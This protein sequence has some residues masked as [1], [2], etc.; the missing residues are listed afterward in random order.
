MLVDEAT[1]TVRSGSGGRGCVSFRREKYVPRGGP[2]G[3]TGGRG[4]SVFLE[5]DSSL[6][7]LLDIS[8]RSL[9]AA[10][11]GRPGGGNNKSGRNGKDLT[12]RLPLGTVV[13]EA[14][15]T[16][17]RA[18]WPLLG[19]LLKAS[20]PLV[21]ARG[22]RGGRGNASFATA[23]YQA[24]REAE[25]GEPAEERKLYLELKLMA[26][27]GLVGLPNAG[28]STL[29]SRIS[30]ATP[31]IAAYP[32]TTLEPHLG[33]VEAG[34]FRRLVFADVPGIIEGAHAGHGLGIE[35]LRHLER[36]RVLV[37]LVSVESLS[38]A[39]AAAAYRTVEAELYQH[40]RVLAEKPRLLAASKL[41]LLP[42]EEGER[43][44]ADLGRLLQVDVLPLSAVTGLGVKALVSAVL[45]LVDGESPAS[46]SPSGTPGLA[47]R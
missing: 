28:K 13:R 46:P 36:T 38:V 32:F 27:V 18:R 25:E 35:F 43:F 47:P 30:A 42:P 5:G 21:V 15:E 10:E 11:D 20:E 26:D 3:G 1:I 16:V 8:R 2:D 34:D 45:R 29:L 7:T 19:E 37:H 40:S 17:P 33:I 39:A 22:G 14:L 24:P 31:K 41:D 6:S 23:T 4:G 9:Y 44:A 12:L